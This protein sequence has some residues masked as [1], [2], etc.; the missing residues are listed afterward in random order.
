[1]VTGFYGGMGFNPV[2]TFDWNVAGPSNTILV[3]PFFSA[4]QQ[5]GARVLSGLIIIGMYWG[6]MYWASYMPINSNEAF[7]NQGKV[8]Q[9]GNILNN[10]T[11]TVDVESYK[12][13]G[14]PYFSG[15][16]VFGQGA[17]FTWY[18]MTLFY[19]CITE[20][21]ALKKA[22]V[23]M[24]GSI[25]HRRSVYDQFRDPH[26]RMMAK[27]KPCPATFPFTT[28]LPVA[29]A[30]QLTRDTDPEVA[31]W[32]FWCVLAVSMVFGII[33]LEV[34]PVNT[35]VWTLFAVAGISLILLIPSAII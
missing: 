18:P 7:D 14:P 2:P 29:S 32:W 19:T 21:K 24:W 3:T 20:W 13:Y 6:N 31:D 33:A 5:Y 35:P 12:E 22:F 34:W 9:V 10:Q 28:Q 17:W 27:C 16:N 23:G 15:A 11:Q 8:Y 4:L 25:R 1:M 26:T 30:D